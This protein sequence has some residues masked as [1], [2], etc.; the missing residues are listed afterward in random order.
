MFKNLIPISLILIPLF[1]SFFFGFSVLLTGFFLEKKIYFI[2]L[3]SLVFSLLEYL[4]GN[5]LTGFPWNLIS[6]TWS[7]SIESVQILSLI[8]TYSLSLISITL[9]CLPFL[10]FQKKINKNNLIFTLIFV[11][12]F[13]VNYLYGSNRINKNVY[14]FD[15]DINVKIISPN[16]SLKD[17]KDNTEISQLKRLIKISNPEKNKK[18]LFI[19]PE[20]IFYESNLKYIKNYESLFSNEFSENHLIALGINNFKEQK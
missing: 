18:T 11:I 16:F 12:I 20:G 1:L 5:I 3:F 14:D 7:W 2:L 4:R 15:K 8:G 9:F 6:Y 17:Y 10:Y 13:T 19:W